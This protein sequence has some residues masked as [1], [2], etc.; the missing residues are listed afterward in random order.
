MLLKQLGRQV[1]GEGS[2][3]AGLTVER[4]FLIDSVGADSTQFSLRDGSGLSH[5]NVVSPLTFARL[6]LWLRSRPNFPWFEHALPVAGRN[7]TVRDRMVG[8]ALEGKVRGKTGSISRVNAF[9]GYVTTP[10]GKT[11]IFSIQ[12]NNHDLAGSAMI[13]RIDSL[14]LEIGKR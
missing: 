7:G 14:V 12:T 3:R 8:T 10:D 5:V 9:S 6:L 1:A 2:W 13:A 11:R 4:R